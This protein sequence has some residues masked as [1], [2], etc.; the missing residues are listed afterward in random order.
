MNMT[1][2]DERLQVLMNDI[3]YTKWNKNN[4]R[5]FISLATGDQLNWTGNRNVSVMPVLIK[6][7]NFGP[8]INDNEKFDLMKQVLEKGGSPNVQSDYWTKLTPLMLAT[9][10]KNNPFRF[11]DTLIQSGADLNLQDSEGQTALIKSI[12]YLSVNNTPEIAKILIDNG[13]DVSIKDSKTL[14]VLMYCASD[15]YASDDY[16]YQS[17]KY[18]LTSNIN[19]NDT[20][21]NGRTAL[22]MSAENKMA[23]LARLLIET[24][25]N[26]NDTD[27]NG[28]T[29]LMIACNSIKR[30]LPDGRTQFDDVIQT[31]LDAGTNI[32]IKSV[33]NQTA[34]DILKIR[35]PNSDIFE[36]LERAMYMTMSTAPQNNTRRGVRRRL[37]DESI[38]DTLI[39]QKDIKININQT[40]DFFDPIMQEET[41]INI[42]EYFK[43]NNKNIV[44]AYGSNYQN[45]FFT[46]RDT[47]N[48]QFQDS[49]VYPCK[50]VDTLRREN[51]IET[52]PLYDLKKIGLTEGSF[53]NMSEFIRKKTHQ[54]FVI[55]DTGKT[56]PSFV[57]DNVLKGTTDHVSALHCQAGQEG[58][59]SQLITATPVETALGG[60]RKKT[61][62]L[63]KTRIN[64]RRTNKKNKHHKSKQTKSKYSKSNKHRSKH[65]PKITR[66]LRKVNKN[67]K[68]TKKV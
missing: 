37:E 47:I 33:R 25:A 49:L 26:V 60:K 57:S 35:A 43:Q 41:K 13:A 7:L 10:I 16:L 66:K 63:H 28:F 30:T 12:I 55:D 3:E 32:R 44:I 6:L 15:K 36:T 2:P 8:E 4:L 31:L 38:G 42:K 39:K 14:N 51:I 24:D 20:D 34:Y 59:V 19:V 11:I 50:E 9:T 56:Y 5:E 48:E 68:R 46:D 52:E 64:K 61:Y 67:M 27:K 40:I 1:E 45:F 29:A 18:I 21:S 17:M 62:K 22:M 65:K 54:L 58:R 53:C 23:D